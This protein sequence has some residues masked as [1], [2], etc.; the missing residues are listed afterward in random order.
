VKRFHDAYEDAVLEQDLLMIDTDGSKSSRGTAVAWTIEECGMTECVCAFATPSTWGI[1]VCEIFSIIAALRDVRLDF[2]GWISIFSDWVPAIMCIAQM[3]SEGEVA[4]MWDTLTPLFNRLSE[5]RVSW[6]PGHCG[7]AGNEMAEAKAN[8]AVGGILRVRTWAGV[9]LGLGPTRIARDPR[10]TEWVHWDKTEGHGS[11]DRTPKKPRYL[12][13]L[14]RLDH[15]ILLRIRSGTGVIGHDDCL[16]TRDRFHR[17]SCDRYMTKRPRFPTLFND[18]HVPDWGVWWQSHF[19]LC[20][21][22]SYEH[23]DNDGVVTVCGNP[24]QQMVTQLINSTLSLFHLGVPDSRCTRCLLKSCNGSDK[25]KLPL[26]FRTVGGGSKQVTLTW[27]PSVSPCVKC[28]SR[29]KIFHVHLRPFPVWARFH[30]WPFWDHIMTRWDE[31][32]VVDRN[33]TVLQWWAV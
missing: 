33:T 28:D 1:V 7:I 4:G 18:K 10:Q 17:V 13:G 22:I 15:Y 25:C 11:Y 14:S 21:G 6:I 26:K 3:E 31:L 23:T 2:D 24:F 32:P 9:V 30:F 19:N 8:G 16:G 12:R 29:A 27:W 5:V 20:M